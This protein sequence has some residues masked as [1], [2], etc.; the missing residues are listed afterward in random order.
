MFISFHFS[1]LLKE[2]DFWYQISCLPQSTNK[3]HSFQW[4]QVKKKA[5]ST[6]EVTGIQTGLRKMY[7]H[8]M[9][10]WPLRGIM[11]ISSNLVALGRIQQNISTATTILENVV[12]TCDTWVWKMENAGPGVTQHL[13][14]SGQL[15]ILPSENMG[16]CYSAFHEV[17]T[18]EPALVVSQG[19]NV[20]LAITLISSKINEI[21]IS[22]IWK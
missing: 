17:G 16:N 5:F 14:T 20:W 15:S 18:A 12:C 21:F 6:I 7:E 1:P 4:C 3:S 19:G 2:P 13:W 8:F 10:L 9:Q 22:W 11:Y